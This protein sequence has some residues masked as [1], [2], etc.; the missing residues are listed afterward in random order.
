[1]AVDIGHSAV[2]GSKL[3]GLITY[4][5]LT[6][7]CNAIGYVNTV[8]I[9]TDANATYYPIASL[10][11]GVFYGSDTSWTCRAS[12]SLGKVTTT[13]VKTITGLNLSCD[14]N[15]ILGTYFTQGSPA[16]ASVHCGNTG[17]S[18][19]LQY[20]GS[21]FTGTQTYTVSSSTGWVSS[22]ATGI[23]YDVTPDQFYFTDQ[24]NVPLSSLRTSNTITATGI[25]YTT[26]LS[27]SGGEYS[28]NGGAWT[29]AAGSVVNDDT[30]AV[31]HT[32]S[33]SY[34]TAVN[35]TL[36]IGGVSDTFTS[37]TKQQLKTAIFVHH[38]RMQGM[39]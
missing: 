21:G 28:I 14:V 13:G 23:E 9:Y 16:G 5:D 11:V 36:T 10:R 22:Y 1:M 37:T 24:T 15:D 6:N 20:S 29:S 33:S 30:V 18:G 7:P 39:S 32:S 8:Q 25:D 4:L 31:R 2:S 3:A 38:R 26:P 19:R 12:A 35:T 34:N 17:G 27:I